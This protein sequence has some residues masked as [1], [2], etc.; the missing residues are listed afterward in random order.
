MDRLE[1]IIEI[2]KNEFNANCG[3]HSCGGCKYNNGDCGLDYLMDALFRW[4]KTFKKDKSITLKNIDVSNKNI[5]G[6]GRKVIEHGENFVETVVDYRFTATDDTEEYKKYAIEDFWNMVQSG[7][8]LL[9]NAGIDA[10]EVMEGYNEYL[11][12]IKNRPLNY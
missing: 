2:M 12:K 11:E 7:L 5:W 8:G 6:Q 10:E 4:D 9:Q 1:K 3:E